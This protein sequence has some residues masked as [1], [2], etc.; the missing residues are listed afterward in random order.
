MT[1]PRYLGAARLRRLLDAHGVR[2]RK[3]LGQNFV[4]DPNTIRKVVAVSGVTPGD[5]VVEVGAGCG[6]L[7][8]GLAAAGARVVAIEFDDRILPI[9]R[10]VA[11][12]IDGV[13]IVRGDAMTI[14]LGDV[15]ADRLVGN[16]PYNIA[17]PLVMRVLQDVPRITDLTVMVQKEVGERFAAVPGSKSYGQVSVVIRYFA[18]ASVVARVSRRAFFPEPNVDSV[19]VKIARSPSRLEVDRDRLFLV[20][21]AA[22]SQRRKTL[23]NTLASV[24]GSTERAEAALSR[25]GVAADARPEQ[26]D[27]PGFIS[28]ADALEREDRS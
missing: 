22:F 10:E 4:L 3:E 23:R 28:I 1:E 18:T 17:T 13:E 25:A 2:P 9:L 12:A 8:L 7:T 11:G 5:R 14:A 15:D 19:V 21:R 27:L 6:S 16:L 20:V 24:A 26:V